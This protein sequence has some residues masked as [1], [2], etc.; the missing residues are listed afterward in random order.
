MKVV[1]V[2]VWQDNYAYLIVNE[3]DRTIGVVDP[4]D[5]EKVIN[6]AKP[7]NFPI[8]YILTT[9]HHGDHASG[10]E[11]MKQLFPDL[12]V[13]GGDNR[14]PAM[15][16]PLKDGD[17]FKTFGHTNSSISYYIEDNK[18]KVVFTGDTLFIAGCGRLFEGTPEQM[19]ESLNIKLAALDKETKVYVGHE[20]TKSNIKFALHVDKDNLLLKQKAELYASTSIT[21]PSTIQNELDINPFMRV[22]LPSLQKFTGQT[23]PI[24]VLGALR[25]MKDKF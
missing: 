9:H 24:M 23:D 3:A 1:P 13:Y 17:T 15:T 2:P 11:R 19:H 18:D 21:V 8:E 12:A 5:P 14:I 22:H 10:N 16:H 4:V 20:Y 6:A 25:A 7:Y